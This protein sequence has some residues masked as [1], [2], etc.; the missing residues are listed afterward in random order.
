MIATGSADVV[1]N[2]WSYDLCKL[3]GSGSIGETRR[4]GFKSQCS[5]H[6][7]LASKIDGIEF[8]VTEI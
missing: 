1:M 8:E 4:S 6:L 3:M 5:H 7:I 2:D